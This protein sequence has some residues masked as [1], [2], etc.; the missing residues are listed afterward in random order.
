[1]VRRGG[2]FLA[3][4]SPTEGSEQ[5]GQRPVVV[6][7]RDAINQNSPV[8]IVVPLTDRE[9]KPRIYPSQVVLKAGDGG[10]AI[11]SVA[12]GEQVRAISKTRLVKPLGHLSPRSITEISAALKIALDLP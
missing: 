11:D 6:V 8:V 12:L 1:M 5:A 7:S 9:N 10:L 3:R 4:L 2:V